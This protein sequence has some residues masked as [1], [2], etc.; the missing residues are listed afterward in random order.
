M[1]TIPTPSAYQREIKETEQ[2]CSPYTLI[3][4]EEQIDVISTG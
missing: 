4:G 1:R 3:D 2:K